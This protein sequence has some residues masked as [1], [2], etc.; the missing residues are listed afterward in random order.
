MI[1]F[2]IESHP[3]TKQEDVKH[4]MAPWTKALGKLS[5]DLT[6]KHDSFTAFIRVTAALTVVSTILAIALAGLGF[7]SLT[8]WHGKPAR[9]MLYMGAFA[10]ACM[11]TAAG[12]MAIFAMNHG[13]RAVIE[14][15]GIEQGNERTF[16][17]P[18][19]F[20]LFAG[21][22]FKLISIGVFFILAF[23]AVLLVVFL[24]YCCIGRKKKDRDLESDE[25]PITGYPEQ[26]TYAQ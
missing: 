21:A 20:V 19:F 25:I 24:V 2:G 12:V 9:W 22:F 17:G 15:S 8:F 13:P 10:D 1:S 3:G 6:A 18:G 14:M 7:A 5:S 16:V 11:F 23:S 26:K 4:L